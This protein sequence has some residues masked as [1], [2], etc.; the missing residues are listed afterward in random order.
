MGV[1]HWPKGM[2][3]D[4]YMIQTHTWHV[5]Y[6]VCLIKFLL[7]CSSVNT[8]LIP[9]KE[10]IR[11]LHHIFTVFDPTKSKPTPKIYSALQ[12]PPNM[13]ASL[14]VIDIFFLLTSPAWKAEQKK[15]ILLKIWHD[16]L[17]HWQVLQQR[18]HAR[19]AGTRSRVTVTFSELCSSFPV[20]SRSSTYRSREFL[21]MF[22]SDC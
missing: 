9:R 10:A 19:G 6:T 7:F 20:R 15:K 17:K 2:L 12:S 11:G 18:N 3:G 4:E 8:F 16:F 13:S 14:F 5:R 22:L 21:C 1:L